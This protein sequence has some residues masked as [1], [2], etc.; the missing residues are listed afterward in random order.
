MR[1]ITG[2]LRL[3]RPEQWVKTSF[4]F[5]P[6]VLAGHFLDGHAWLTTLVAAVSTTA[7]M[8]AVYCYNDI[9]DVAE[10][11]QHPRKCHRPIASGVVSVATGYVLMAGCAVASV[12]TAVWGCR[13]IE[14]PPTVLLC[15]DVVYL[16]LNV[17]YCHVLRRL[18]VAD[19][20]C[21]AT[22]FVLR[23]WAGESV[24]GF[25]VS[26]WMYAFLF[27]L[28]SLFALSKRRDDVVLYRQS[29][30]AMRPNV[31][32]YRLWAVDLTLHVLVAGIVGCYVMFT[33]S[34]QVRHQFAAPWLW[35]S[36][37]PVLLGLSRYLYI[38]IA[39]RGSGSPTRVVATDVVMLL[40]LF[41]WLAWFM[42]Q[43]KHV[44]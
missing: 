34:Q 36:A 25:A 5:A 4:V 43:I 9:H 1:R 37:L 40:C 31:R 27:L 44:L 16:L 11:R 12:L 15:M 32:G 29:G 26:P 33:C 39:R 10:D 24:S 14:R 41:G 8:S 18:P 35:T 17:A 6:M 21:I 3:L 13:W 23:V 20:L 38:T 2:I 7:M 22:G 28:I 19:V 30:V 42:L